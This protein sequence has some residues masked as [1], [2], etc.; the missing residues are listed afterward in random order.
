MSVHLRS[1]ALVR[2]QALVARLSEGANLTFLGQGF[3]D[4]FMPGF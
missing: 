1:S 2:M 4:E 3:M